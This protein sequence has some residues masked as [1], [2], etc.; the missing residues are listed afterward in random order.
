MVNN[1]YD[2]K[3]LRYKIK[4]IFYSI[5]VIKCKENKRINQQSNNKKR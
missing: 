2:N 5:M 1:K 4:S 3:S